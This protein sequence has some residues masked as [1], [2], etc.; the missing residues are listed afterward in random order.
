MSLAGAVAA[1]V[2]GRSGSRAQANSTSAT[3]GVILNPDAV[4]R[5]DARAA[6]AH[7]PG[8][9]GSPQMIAL[10][11]TLRGPVLR[12][13]KGEPLAVMLTNHTDQPMTLQWHGMCC[14]DAVDGLIGLDA[15]AIV[16]GAGASIRFTPIDSGLSWFHAAMVPNRT[17]QTA[18][19]VRGVLIVDEQQPPTVDRDFL[20]L[21]ADWPTP[22]GAQVL[23][24]GGGL[25]EKVTMAPGGRLRLR[26]VNGSTSR[27]ML[28]AIEGARPFIIAIDGQPSELFEPVKDM[29]PIGPGA[30]FEFMLDVPRT[31]GATMRLTL[32]G[33]ERVEGVLEPDRLVLEVRTDGPVRDQ[34][35]PIVALPRNPRL[36][37]AIPL[38]QSVR[39]DLAMEQVPASAGQA[40]WRLNGTATLDLPAHP[41]LTV[42]RGGTVTLGFANRS[43]QSIALRVHG[44]V[45]RLLHSKD[46]GWEP[47]WR[48]SVLLPPQTSN[49]VAFVADNPGKWMI[50]SAIYDQVAFGLRHWFEVTA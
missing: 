28:V 25:A 19:G 41:L 5:L 45:M 30:R 48:D 3:G 1:L 21:L 2:A 14:P 31:S 16:P 9:A 39:A 43:S 24:N 15:P 6:P 13:K 12:I 49:H 17:D 7:I 4:T 22:G 11:G 46:D 27:I 36:P 26:V 44:H 18:H 23:I 32:R 8:L 42:K 37:P 33:T 10:D 50:E 34:I 29:V 47:Y 35:P 40:R 38:E 20:V